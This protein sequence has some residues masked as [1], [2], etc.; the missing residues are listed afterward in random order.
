LCAGEQNIART[1]SSAPASGEASTARAAL[2]G[3]RRCGCPPLRADAADPAAAAAAAAAVRALPPG[4]GDTSAGARCGVPVNCSSWS[5]PQLAPPPLPCTAG[6]DSQPPTPSLGG[7]N[8]G[9]WLGVPR[10]LYAPFQVGSGE[11]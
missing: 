1:R 10:M 4:E 8:S 7:W 11:A 9:S 2:A 3:V 5:A 6:E